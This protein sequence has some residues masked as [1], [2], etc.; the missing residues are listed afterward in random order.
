MYTSG[1]LEKTLALN[2]LLVLHFTALLVY[3]QSTVG[4]FFSYTIY[5]LYI[6]TKIGCVFLGRDTSNYFGAFF[7]IFVSLKRI[8][9]I[10]SKIIGGT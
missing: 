8:I 5:I 4:L 3:F 2:S 10:F 7:R 9:C 1:V 6:T